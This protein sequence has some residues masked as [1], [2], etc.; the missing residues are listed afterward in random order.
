MKMRT[1]NVM[2]A[3]FA[4]AC[5]SAVGCSQPEPVK[6]QYEPADCECSDPEA[7]GE[8]PGA[9][10][11]SSSAEA[12]EPAEPDGLADEVFVPEEE[13]AM[14]AVN[15]DGQEEAESSDDDQ[16]SEQAP[17]ASQSASGVVNLN[18]ASIDQLMS[19]PGVGPALA[20]RIVEFRQQRRFDKPRHLLR[21]KG[22]GEST[23]AKLEPMLAV[24]GP[25]TLTK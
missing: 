21:V 25:T 5:T 18:D 4:L 1:L 12:A 11:Q 15:W 20:A 16:A 22:I 3:I 8:E 14:V 6:A 17:A 24:D 23:Y 19:L 10:E 7:A 2:F 9:P 13:P